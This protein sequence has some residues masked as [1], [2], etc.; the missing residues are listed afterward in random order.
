M[1]ST[2]A[3]LIQRIDERTNE[4]EILAEKLRT[5]EAETRR[6]QNDANRDG[7][8]WQDCESKLAAIRQVVT[9]ELKVRHGVGV[10]PETEW[11]NGQDVSKEDTTPEIRLLRH[12]HELSNTQPPF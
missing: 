7:K 3:E 11:F 9:A 1:A 4:N 6:F 5:A 8:N 2:K 12:L 10:Q